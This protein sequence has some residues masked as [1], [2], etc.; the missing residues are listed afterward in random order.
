MK[1][2]TFL[3]MFA[4]VSLGRAIGCS[5]DSLPP[6]DAELARS[7]AVFVGRVVQ[8]SIESRSEDNYRYEVTVC[9]FQVI[10]AFKGL[11]EQ[12]KEFTVITRMSGTACGFPF[13]LG[14]RYLVYASSYHGDMETSLCRRTRALIQPKEATVIVPPP[15]PD[16]LFNKKETMDE[17]GRIEAEQLRAFLEKK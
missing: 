12:K 11:E 2:L 3:F 8:M 5:C 9:R 14:N 16:H 4:A 10:E 13:E 15:P 17:S 7:D 1:Q 6:M